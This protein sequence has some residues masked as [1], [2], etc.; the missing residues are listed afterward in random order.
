MQHVFGWKSDLTNLLPLLGTG[1]TGDNL[2]ITREAIPA[3]AL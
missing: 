2:Y 1:P 3:W